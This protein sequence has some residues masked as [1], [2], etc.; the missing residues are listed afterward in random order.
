[1]LNTKLWALLILLLGVIGCGGDGLHDGGFFSEFVVVNSSNYSIELEY[2]LPSANE[3]DSELVI[4]EPGDSET[5]HRAFSMASDIS[6]APSP[7]STFLSL[8]VSLVE[9][10]ETIESESMLEDS[11]WQQHVESQVTFYTLAVIDQDFF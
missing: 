7:E 11:Q 5:F 9:D 10:G 6:G 1:M 2:T 3:A 8:D 4:V